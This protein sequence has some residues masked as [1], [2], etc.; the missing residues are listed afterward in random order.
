MNDEGDKG[1]MTDRQIWFVAIA[2][3]LILLIVI[4]TTSGWLRFGWGPEEQPAPTQIDL[5]D[6]ET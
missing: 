5:R 4:L 6:L 3:F 2:L 1:T